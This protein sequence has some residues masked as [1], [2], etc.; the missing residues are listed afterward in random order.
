MS[1][2]DKLKV[3]VNSI[4]IS[5]RK[6]ETLTYSKYVKNEE[7]G[8]GVD[9]ELNERVKK[10]DELETAQL[11]DGSV[12]RPKLAEGSVDATKMDSDLM[13][14]IETAT[15][16]PDNLV[17]QFEDHSENLAKL[18][19]T[20]YPITLGLTVSPNVS[21]M[22][23]EVKYSVTSDGKPFT[24]DTLM[25]EKQINDTTNKVLAN[26]PFSSATLD[27]PIEGARET[28]K[29]SVTKQGRTGKSLSLIHI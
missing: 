8:K 16:L 24:P 5:G 27:T 11:K 15:G 4:L 23:T 19:D 26:T 29:L 9:E 3:K 2:L 18:N 10:T 25:L 22:Q 12:T 6:D 13:N 20:V 7:T 17:K 21:T 1:I 28:F 14:M